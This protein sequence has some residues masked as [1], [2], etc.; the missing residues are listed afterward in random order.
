[1]NCVYTT[2]FMKHKIT[3]LFLLNST[4]L[5]AQEIV[6]FRGDDRSGLYNET[7]LLKQWPESGPELL[8]K[9]EG[10][11]KGYSQPIFVDETIFRQ[12]LERFNNANS[13]FNW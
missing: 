6:E 12:G 4:A 11:G 8:L 2:I 13:T 7:G 5:F 1:M 3:I 10:I 9:I